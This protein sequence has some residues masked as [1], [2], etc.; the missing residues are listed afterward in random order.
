MKIYTIRIIRLIIDHAIRVLT[1]TKKLQIKTIYNHLISTRIKHLQK[2]NEWDMHPSHN[3][4]MH[5]SSPPSPSSKAFL[6]LN[7]KNM[8]NYIDYK[9]KK[10]L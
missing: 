7:S 9:I 2:K 3:S 10:T 6:H 5:R 4:H 1:T 8:P